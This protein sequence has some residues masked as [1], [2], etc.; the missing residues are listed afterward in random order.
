[1]QGARFAPLGE[2][3][4]AAQA[5]LARLGERHAL[6]W[7]RQKFAGENV[8]M[9]HHAVQFVADEGILLLWPDLDRLADAENADVA[10]HACEALEQLRESCMFPASPR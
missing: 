3:Q 8:A 2:V 1:L 7:F 5:A 10:Y 4:N 6:Q 9:I